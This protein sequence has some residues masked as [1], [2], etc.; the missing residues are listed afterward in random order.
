MTFELY[1]STYRSAA[2]KLANKHHH[3]RAEVLRKHAEESGITA[4]SK[5][6]GFDREYHHPFIFSENKILTKSRLPKSL[7]LGKFFII[8]HEFRNNCFCVKFGSDYGKS[9]LVLIKFTRKGDM[10]MEIS[11]NGD[12]VEFLFSNR[13]DAINFRKYVLESIDDSSGNST[14]IK[15][16]KEKLKPESILINSLYTTF[17]EKPIPDDWEDEFVDGG[18][19]GVNNTYVDEDEEDY[20]DEEDGYD[21]EDEYREDRYRNLER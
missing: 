13:K 18:D 11:Y 20:E 16:A 8:G 9:F 12:V 10:Y 14:A 21:E 19:V 3:S 5:K 1:K 6:D 15:Y 7:F 2:K 4:F 17:G